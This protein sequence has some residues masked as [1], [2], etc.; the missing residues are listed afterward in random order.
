MGRRVCLLCW[1]VQAV[2]ARGNAKTERQSIERERQPDYRQGNVRE[3][4]GHP[5]LSFARLVCM[6][7][8]AWSRDA[9]SGILFL[10]IHARTHST[11][12]GCR[13][14]TRRTDIHAEREASRR[15]YVRKLS[16]DR[17]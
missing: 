3:G 6:W 1:L 14:Q 11:G 4:R 2:G 9:H 17:L 7:A 16:A 10:L 12:L 8:S 15:I 5:F 13:Y